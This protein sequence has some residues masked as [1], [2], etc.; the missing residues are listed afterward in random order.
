VVDIEDFN[1]TYT[2]D[3]SNCPRNTLTVTST[4]SKCYIWNNR[5][6]CEG[7]GC[8]YYIQF[9][10]NTWNVRLT[11]YPRSELKITIW[12]SNGAVTEGTWKC[13]NTTSS[14][15]GWK[16][17]HIYE[18]ENGY[19]NHEIK[20]VGNFGRTQAYNFECRKSNGTLKCKFMF[21]CIL[22]LK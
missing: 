6:N 9:E 13:R 14:N 3:A 1:I 7:W 11:C 2:V 20:F 4:A 10:P 19:L 18:D 17:A 22:V 21:Y 16:H 8:Y 12:P 5:Y 15:G